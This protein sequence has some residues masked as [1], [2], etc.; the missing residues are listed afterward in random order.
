MAATNWKSEVAVE[1]KKT[2]F[3][4]YSH[5]WYQF[6]QFQLL[7]ILKWVGFRFDV[8]AQM[9]FHFDKYPVVKIGS[10]NEYLS[11]SSVDYITFLSIRS[12]N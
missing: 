7:D 12:F 6:S 8:D 10:T 5:C 1:Q 11:P 9:K 2:W 3:V 4:N